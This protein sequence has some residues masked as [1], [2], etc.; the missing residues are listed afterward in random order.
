MTY[1]QIIIFSLS[2][3]VS[4]FPAIDFPTVI[5]LKSTDLANELSFYRR[6]AFKKHM[7]IMHWVQQLCNCPSEP[8]LSSLSLSA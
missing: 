7:T 8:W 3:P 2:F 1:F 4:A 6:A 5:S